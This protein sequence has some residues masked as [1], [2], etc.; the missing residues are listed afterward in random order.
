MEFLLIGSATV[1]LVAGSLYAFGVGRRRQR[2]SKILEEARLR[3]AERAKN[4]SFADTQPSDHWADRLDMTTALD[5]TEVD[6]RFDGRGSLDDM[7]KR[8]ISVLLE[9]VDISYVDATDRDNY[10]FSGTNRVE[11]VAA[12]PWRNAK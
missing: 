3:A 4:R 6:D 5:F 8:T 10:V 1:L 11:P 9:G 7:Q 2:E 12:D